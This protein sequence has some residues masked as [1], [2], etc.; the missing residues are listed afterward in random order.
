MFVRACVRA[1][2][3]AHV[4]ACAI[5]NAQYIIAGRIDSVYGAQR[6]RV[7]AVGYVR[8]LANVM[9]LF[10]Y[11]DTALDPGGI[12]VSHFIGLHNSSVRPLGCIASVAS[13]AFVARG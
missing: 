2:V 10:C 1:C 6:G 5:D 8:I 7:R 4:P 11:P 3:R 9:E 13:L 12:M